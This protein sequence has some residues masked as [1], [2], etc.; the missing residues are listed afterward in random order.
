MSDDDQDPIARTGTFMT[1]AGWILFGGLLIAFFGNMLEKQHN[2]NQDPVTGFTGE[3]REVV[4]ERNRFGHYVATGQI[5]GKDVV[6][7][8]DTG[9]TDV[10]VPESTANRL[11]LIKGRPVR[12]RT[13]NGI[14]RAWD[15]RINT[16]SLGEIS[17]NNVDATILDNSGTDQIL[18]GM[19][20]LKNLEMVQKG[21]R[22][23]IR[24]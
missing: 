1:V 22:L 23:T 2:P 12:A 4:L 3:H 7:L 24:Q 15:T 20:F 14:A 19:S 11:G 21:N 13:A 6:F 8:L 10:A 17:L 9:A 5:N 16:V 18:L